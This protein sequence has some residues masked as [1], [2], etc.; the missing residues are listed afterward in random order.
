MSWYSVCDNFFW[1]GHL[2]TA[3]I[4]FARSDKGEEENEEKPL[5]PVAL[6][7][8]CISCPVA[9]FYGQFSWNQQYAIENW[10][11]VLNLYK[12]IWE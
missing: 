12:C 5:K 9:I 3:K 4:L 8:C 7:F 1:I 6:H 11:C 10:K 2:S